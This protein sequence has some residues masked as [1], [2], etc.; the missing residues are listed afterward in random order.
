[1]TTNGKSND[2]Y[3]DKGFW[4]SLSNDLLKLNISEYQE[5]TEK[6]VGIFKSKEGEI[7]SDEVIYTA[8]ELNID[9]KSFKA[10]KGM[11]IK[12]QIEELE[13]KKKLALK[14]YQANKLTDKQRKAINAVLKGESDIRK[15]LKGLFEQAKI[16]LLKLVKAT[17]AN[18]H[19]AC[20]NIHLVHNVVIPLTKSILVGQMACDAFLAICKAFF[21]SSEETGKEVGIACL[22]YLG[23]NAY[24]NQEGS[25]PIVDQFTKMFKSLSALCI[26]IDIDIEPED[27][28]EE[29][30]LW[31]DLM[32]VEKLVIL[33]PVIEKLL[34]S[35]YSIDFKMQV[36][37]FLRLA[38][39]GKFLKPKDIVM[40]PVVVLMKF[41][42]KQMCADPSLDTFDDLKECITNY[43]N[44]IQNITEPDDLL[45]SYL[46]DILAVLKN[47]AELLRHLALQWLASMDKY[48][49]VQ[50]RNDIDFKQELMGSLYL[51]QVDQDAR[52]VEIAT[53]LWIHLRFVESPVLAPEIFSATIHEYDFVQDEAAEAI[54]YLSSEFP[55][56]VDNA[57]VELF[58]I[59]D[60]Y[61]EIIPPVKDRVGRV[62]K[63]G[64]DPTMERLGVGKSLCRLSDVIPVNKCYSF[65][66]EIVARLD[67]RDRTVHSTLIRAGTIAIKAH[68]QQ[69]MG[70]LL[71]FLENTL[72]KTPTSS[73]GD[74]VRQGLVVF[75]GTLG[76]YLG[77]EPNRI[78][79]IFK[80]LIETLSTPSEPVQ[81]SVA[82]CLPLLVGFI[83]TQAHETLESLLH[84]MVA[85]TNYGERR[86]AAYGIAA[87][88]HGLKAYVI[89]ET[90]LIQ[91]IE[92]MVTNKNNAN[93]RESGLMI[94]ELMFKIMG[95]SSEPFVPLFIPHLLATYGDKD[96]HVR[97]AATEAVQ[98]MMASLSQYGAKLIVPLILKSTETDNWR[99]KRAAA[100]LLGGVS[101]CAPRQLSSCLP[102][103]V[104]TLVE[105]LA[106]SHHEVQKSGTRALKEIAKVIRNPEIMAISP[107][108]IS[109]L[110][111]PV[112]KTSAA[113]E[114][115]VNTRFIHYM[116]PPALAL[117]MPIVRRAFSERNTQARM[118]SA[119]IV[120]NI[121][122]LTDKRDMEP[123]LDTVIPGL[124]SALLDPVPEVRTVAA[125]AFGAVLR[126]SSEQIRD[127]VAQM[128]IPWLKQRLVSKTSMVD[129]S[130][131]AQG[132]AE[133]I[134]AFGEE[135]LDASMPEVLQ[136]AEDPKTDPFVRDGYLLLF[137]YLPIVL[138]DKFVS[139]LSSVVSP[140]LVS[141]ADENEIVRA[142]ALR[143][144]QQLINM[145]IKDARTTLLPQLQKSLFH[146][147]WRIRHATVQ[148][149]G[150]YLFNISGVSGKMSSATNDED[151]TL[152]IELIN[153]AIIQN[154]G[155]QSRDEILSGLYLCRQDVAL[156]VRQAA[157]HVWKVVVPNTPR[158]LRDIME[159]LF[160]LLLKCLA[161]KSKERQQTAAR[162]L[163]EVVKKMGERLLQTVMPI[164]KKNLES[165]MVDQ[166][167][168]VAEA[169][170]EIVNNCSTDSLNT[171]AGDLM[172]LLN[173]CLSDSASSVRA[174]AASPFNEL[175]Q[176]VGQSAVDEIIIPMVDKYM[177]SKD[178]DSLDALCSI[179][180]VNPKAFL[181]PILKKMIK[182][183]VDTYGLCRIAAS[184]GSEALNKYLP[185]FLEPILS[186]KPK[187]EEMEEFVENCLPALTAITEPDTMQ[188]AI[189]QLLNTTNQGN[190]IGIYLLRKWV[191][192]SEE[193]FDEGIAEDI[194]PNTLA[195]YANDD[196]NVVDQAIAIVGTII[197][198]AEQGH[199]IEYLYPIRGVMDDFKKKKLEKVL[200]FDTP[201]GF[202]VFQQ[203]LKEAFFSGNNTQKE[204]AIAIVDVFSKL[205]SQQALAPHAIFITG[206]LIRSIGDRFL[207][208]TRKS[209]LSTL[210]NLF[211]KTPA[212]I[213]PFIPQLHTE[214]L[215]LMQIENLSSIKELYSSTLGY[216]ISSHMKSE[217]VF[218]DLVQLVGTSEDDKIM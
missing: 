163:G 195:L 170:N 97:T 59:Y 33:N 30:D 164:L 10:M 91:R 43:C 83:D 58:K 188:A 186:S 18:P 132:L 65:I 26:V 98:A 34:L 39:N 117:I 49:T 173:K 3:N 146:E 109:G 187:I 35:Q 196:K 167:L 92:T 88:I 179:V 214:L 140:L 185:K 180:H 44:L 171:N 27:G 52:C 2:D 64:R 17:R 11:S 160:T 38:V 155:R 207:N 60:K 129:R 110:T 153:K 16:N 206:P 119:Q 159:V 54:Y 104:P 166:R 55:E 28:E 25:E 32:T 62:L 210:K 100:E 53:N 19:A 70:S 74:N 51:E 168:G 131:A 174:A 149:I 151:D 90:N 199:A 69:L 66:E 198:K 143:A 200:G 204:S 103:V 67:E 158:A 205:A 84:I 22:R 128:L 6:D 218:N 121:Y 56:F 80:T 93:L 139:Y 75:L 120:T 107:H 213:R 46:G 141:L 36:T 169:L 112:S 115:V 215:K 156:V 96:E 122:T 82:E 47:P 41:L 189:K 57:F 175:M 190:P 182:P 106:D 102:K 124:Q 86:G 142:T 71:P 81:R 211:E 73:D 37:N 137:I 111:D 42:L 76:M 184:S 161:N 40:E 118:M 126:Y 24:A 95:T 21:K 12:D 148:L 209:A 192:N 135:F 5:I 7:S 68:G 130:G 197:K 113:L 101:Q 87:I 63:E 31:Q 89:V 114:T 177:K 94:M 212:N 125:R 123:Y 147:N 134:A 4:T 79:Q 172:L 208:D 203:V 116:D 191:E 178:H 183:P 72:A 162:C 193:L 157:S 133:A 20:V 23:A 165:N 144:G 85:T 201:T 202:A 154:I 29:D 8:F 13:S 105:L 15:K 45:K 50:I 14:N 108:L 78:L 181:P 127:Q 152:G 136:V 138:K 194:L 9:P 145:Y 176:I 217:N 77:N 61:L 216:A 99:T 48:L 150:D 1:M